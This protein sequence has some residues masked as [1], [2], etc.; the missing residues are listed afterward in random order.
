M[1]QPII[2]RSNRF[3]GNNLVNH[4][5]ITLDQLEEANNALLDKIDAQN[6]KEAS[7]LRILMWELDMLKESDLI[8]F[9]VDQYEI[10]LANMGFYSYLGVEEGEEPLYSLEDCWA[11]WTVPFD[12]EN[13]FYFLATAYYLSQPVIDMWEEKL[14][15]KILW[16][17]TELVGLSTLLENAEKELKTTT[18]NA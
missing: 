10:G 2:L 18:V 11:T 13:G 8:N 16:F 3:L 7:L 6:V 15:G 1:I 4:E 14:A 5:L 9:L 12:Q 17:A